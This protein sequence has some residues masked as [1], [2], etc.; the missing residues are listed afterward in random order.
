MHALQFTEFGSV[1]NLRLIDLPD[2][3]LILQQRSSRSR[4]ARLALAM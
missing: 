3:R 2:P 1:S 4:P